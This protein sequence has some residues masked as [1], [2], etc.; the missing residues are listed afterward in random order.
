M[1]IGFHHSAIDPNLAAFINLLGLGPIQK[2][3]VDR[4][5]SRGLNSGYVGLESGVL[6][7][8]VAKSHP[9]KTADGFRIGNMK[10][11]ITI[12][13]LMNL[14]EE[15]GPK[16]L[17][18]GHAAGAALLAYLTP[19]K[20]LVNQID[21]GIIHIQNATDR[22]QFGR[23]GVINDRGRQGHLFFTFIA[24]F[25]FG[26]FC[27][28]IVFLIGCNFIYTIGRLKSPTQNALFLYKPAR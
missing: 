13:M 24:H 18:G 6:E 26:S 22:F 16:N 4:F 2:H 9:H 27:L 19:G 7:G 10:G 23:F 21:Y 5:P 1:N 28:L 17:F 3:P 25:V 15:R 20:V 8:S 11:Q 14:L 12:S